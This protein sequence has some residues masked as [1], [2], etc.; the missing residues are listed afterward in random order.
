MI[1][2]DA[3]RRLSRAGEDIRNRGVDQVFLALMRSSSAYTVIT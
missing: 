1:S 3:R 2:S